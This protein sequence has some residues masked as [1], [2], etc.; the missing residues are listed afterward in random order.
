[1]N[2]QATRCH[3]LERYFFRITYNMTKVHYGVVGPT[4]QERIHCPISAFQ[5]EWHTH[6]YERS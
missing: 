1:M 2:Y 3:I 5:L 4:K 6:R